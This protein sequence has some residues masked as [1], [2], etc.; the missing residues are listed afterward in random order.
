[1]HPQ[2][3]PLTTCGT[4]LKESDGLDVLGQENYKVT[5]E[6]HLRSVSRAASQILVTFR[7]SCRV[8]HDRSLLVRCFHG[9]SSPFWSTVLPC[10]ARQP[11]H[12]LNY[13]TV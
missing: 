4:V 1:M 8:L 7:K 11:I 12:T 10:G 13:F 3:P 6:K 9:L 2:S 5:F